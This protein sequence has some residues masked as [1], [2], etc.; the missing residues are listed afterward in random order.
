ML[1]SDRLKDQASQ[2]DEWGRTV[3]GKVLKRD[4]VDRALPQVSGFRP[5]GS[6]QDYFHSFQCANTFDTFKGFLGVFLFFLF[7]AF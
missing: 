3:Q 2:R 4:W 1:T 5:R 6:A 7:F